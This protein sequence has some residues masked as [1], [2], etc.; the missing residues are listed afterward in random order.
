MTC[1]RKIIFTFHNSVNFRITRT[2]GDYLAQNLKLPH[3]TYIYFQNMKIPLIIFLVI[4]LG[5]IVKQLK[6]VLS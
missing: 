2:L 3:C 4:F 6:L 5:N 1:I